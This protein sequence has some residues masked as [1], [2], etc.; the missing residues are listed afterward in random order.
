MK[1]ATK[2]VWAYLT[3]CQRKEAVKMPLG[4][5]FAIVTENWN[6]NEILNCAQGC[7]LSRRLKVS[8]ERTTWQFKSKWW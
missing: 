5:V 4:S 6:L 2:P 7:A 1:M 3:R 8:Q